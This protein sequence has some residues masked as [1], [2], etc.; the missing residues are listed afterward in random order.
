[1]K[2]IILILS[3]IISCFYAKAHETDT[4]TY[5]HSWRGYPENEGVPDTFQEIPVT[6]TFD[7]EKGVIC[8]EGSI[9]GDFLFQQF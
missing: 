2:K 3:I 1:M 6:I 7:M 9:Y 8:S 4:L 5:T